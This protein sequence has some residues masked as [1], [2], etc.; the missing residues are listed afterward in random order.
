MEVQEMNC[1]PHMLSI[2]KNCP[3]CS[4]DYTLVLSDAE[5]KQYM[6]YMCGDSLIQEALPEF[7]P[8]EREFIKSGYCEDCQKL[9]FGTNY[10]MPHLIKTEC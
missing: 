5:A 9:L 10:S 1:S 6:N 4:K 3:M 8:A 7:N 2:T